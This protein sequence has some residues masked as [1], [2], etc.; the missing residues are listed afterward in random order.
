M[1]FTCV[2]TAQNA[3]KNMVKGKDSHPLLGLWALNSILKNSMPDT[4]FWICS[5]LS[6]KFIGWDAK[7]AKLTDRHKSTTVSWRR[8][9]TDFVRLFHKFWTKFP[10]KKTNQRSYKSSRFTDSWPRQLLGLPTGKVPLRRLLMI[11]FVLSTYDI[12]QSSPLNEFLIKV[13][14]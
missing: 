3:L 4:N 6:S 5:S 7:N 14:V 13:N 2:S 9:R 1:V 12:N 10:K 8:F 11:N